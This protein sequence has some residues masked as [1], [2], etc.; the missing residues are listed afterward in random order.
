MWLIKNIG[1][2]WRDFP[3]NVICVAEYTLLLESRLFVD[4]II[5]CMS[6][7]IGPLSG[8]VLQSYWQ[9]KRFPVLVSG[10][11]QLIP[12]TGHCVWI[13]VLGVIGNRLLIDLIV[14]IRPFFVPA[15][16]CD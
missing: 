8:C 6:C 5:V 9:T 15:A 3:F 16:R 10:I 14:L 4:Y 11:S 1:H 2:F 13:S 12:E 7:Q